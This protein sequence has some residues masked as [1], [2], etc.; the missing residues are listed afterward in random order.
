MNEQGRP[1]DRG[2]NSEN[3]YS[4]EH[5]LQALVR[6]GIFG[7]ANT[8]LP[9]EVQRIRV[10]LKLLFQYL[11]KVSTNPKCILELTRKLFSIT[12]PVD[13]IYAF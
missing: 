12:G 6:C 5:Q 7:N 1:S 10:G 8:E 4:T 11:I 13:R 9:K 2:L 3:A